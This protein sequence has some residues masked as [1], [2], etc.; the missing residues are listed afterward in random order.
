MNHSLSLS[1]KPN[2]YWLSL[3]PET[4]NLTAQVPLGIN[5]YSTQLY[6]YDKFNLSYIEINV[7]IK[8]IDSQGIQ[9][10]SKQDLY[11]EIIYSGEKFKFD[12]TNYFDIKYLQA[13]RDEI[14]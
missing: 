6:G 10:N 9:I 11:E 8:A 12:L 2:L 5:T 14:V 4:L 3:N 7:N 1:L 13:K